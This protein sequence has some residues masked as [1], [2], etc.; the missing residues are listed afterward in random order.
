MK[1]PINFGQ[2]RRRWRT[3]CVDATH[4]QPDSFRRR[5][6]DQIRQLLPVEFGK[7]M[8]HRVRVAVSYVSTL[9]KRV[10]D[11]IAGRI[12]QLAAE[13]TS[14]GGVGCDVRPMEQ[15]VCAGVCGLDRGPSCKEFVWSLESLIRLDL[16]NDL[17]RFWISRFWPQRGGSSISRS[18]G[19]GAP[20]GVSD[21]QLVGGW[22]EIGQVP[23][24]HTSLQGLRPA[25][26]LGRRLPLDSS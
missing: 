20:V 2:Q 10:P 8:V 13:A 11:L 18:A 25:S 24:H 6:G 21:S 15:Q 7:L 9:V 23:P 16:S 17:R 1:E 19:L 26:A 3:R 12:A 14:S 4:C 22:A 5:G